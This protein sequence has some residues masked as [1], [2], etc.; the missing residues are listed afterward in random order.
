MARQMRR[1]TYT[2]L[3]LQS[4]H[5]IEHA[6]W[7]KVNLEKYEGQTEVVIT[8]LDGI[9]LA[10]RQSIKNL[11]RAYR[12]LR[13]A[14]AV[15]ETSPIPVF[16]IDPVKV[17]EIDAIM[18]ALDSDKTKT[19]QIAK[20]IEE[21]PTKL[22]GISRE[23]TLAVDAIINNIKSAD[24]FL[25]NLVEYEVNIFV[26]FARTLEDLKSITS[27][28]QNNTPEDTTAY[29]K[30][31]FLLAG[32]REFERGEKE[33]LQGNKAKSYAELIDLLAKD[34]PPMVEIYSHINA[35]K[36]NPRKAT[37]ERVLTTLREITITFLKYYKKHRTDFPILRNGLPLT[38]EFIKHI[39]KQAF[40]LADAIEKLP[41][42]TAA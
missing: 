9:G 32:I 6:S 14:I 20:E 10:L 37:P 22:M 3:R 16:D 13:N 25:G 38:R 8:L 5:L 23:T 36:S 18:D 15:Q 7:L 19:I 29:K 11:L 33:A 27:L 17:Q 34:E 40:E 24:I 4:Q 30:A 42:E 41:M 31:I 1:G 28:I 39:S 35:W 26:H 2:T 12:D 21:E